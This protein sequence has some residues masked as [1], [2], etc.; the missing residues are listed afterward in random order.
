MHDDFKITRRAILAGLLATGI[1]AFLPGIAY[2]DQSSGSGSDSDSGG[3]DHSGSGSNSGSDSNDSGGDDDS[4]NDAVDDSGSSHG[5]GRKDR[6]Q[7]K[8]RDAVRNGDAISLSR[9]MGLLKQQHDGRVIAVTFRE[10][11]NRLDY[12]FKLVDGSGKV[13]SVT[14]DARTGRIRGFLGL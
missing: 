14:M 8:A 12:R 6:D 7:D 13:L 4:D 1:A 10:K 2:A 9:A 3:G 5:S 11:G